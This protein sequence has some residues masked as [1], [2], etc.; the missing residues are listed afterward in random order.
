MDIYDLVTQ[1]AEVGT[2]RVKAS[3]VILSQMKMHTHTHLP[4]GGGGVEEE[5]INQ[6]IM[7]E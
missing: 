6:Q 5:R 2:S 1:K 3:L 7:N 4:G